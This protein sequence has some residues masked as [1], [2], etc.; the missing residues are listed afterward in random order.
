MDKRK[1]FIV[2][3]WGTILVGIWVIFDAFNPYILVYGDY[4]L[5]LILISGIL[6]IFGAIISLGIFPVISGFVICGSLI[7]TSFLYELN[8]PILFSFLKALG[9]II[10]GCG[11]IITFEESYELELYGLHH[12]GMGKTEYFALK[13]LGITTLEELVEEKGNEEEICSIT[14]IPIIQLKSWIRKAE[15]LLQE[16]EKRKKEQ[17]RKDFK[18]KQRK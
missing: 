17:L 16:R 2:S 10:A 3:S 15:E 6:G 9:F 1:W 7:Y 8:P 18:E 13:D 12:L 5:Y 14:S 4:Y 11:M